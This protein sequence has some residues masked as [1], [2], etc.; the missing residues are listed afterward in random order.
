M[1]SVVTRDKEGH[2]V[3]QRQ[4]R[5]G[6]VTITPVTA[7]QSQ[8]WEQTLSG[9]AQSLQQSGALPSGSVNDLLAK[10]DVAVP[11]EAGDSQYKVGHYLGLTDKQIAN[12]VVPFNGFDDPHLIRLYHAGDTDVDFVMA[13]KLNGQEQDVSSN[14]VTTYK[15]TAEPPADMAKALTDTKDPA[16]REAM[17]RNY[18]GQ[19]NEDGAFS[20]TMALLGMDFGAD[21]P[22]I[23]RQI[24]DNHL[25]MYQGADEATKKSTVDSLLD[26]NNGDDGF[27]VDSA[28]ALGFPYSPGKV[29]ALEPSQY[30][31]Q[32]TQDFARTLGSVPAEQRDPMIKA[33][34]NDKEGGKHNE[35]AVEL[36]SQ[37]FVGKDGNPVSND[38]AK[39]IRETVFRTRIELIPEKDRNVRLDAIRDMVGK[40]Q[41]G[42]ADYWVDYALAKV[43]TGEFKFKLDE[44]GEMND[45]AKTEAGKADK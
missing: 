3:L 16:Q 21:S 38:E 35:L 4:D 11:D 42:D 7:Q 40:Q 20:N 31:K 37:T 6:Q 17:I 34:L 8:A 15:P 43:A 44:I 29:G 41:D 12:D 39:A 9:Y 14:G 28:K 33:W 2:L 45:K 18:I 5:S 30:V 22:A 10:Y 26:G 19:V 13:P 1:V 24:V 36:A 25:G 27:I 32:S 23:K